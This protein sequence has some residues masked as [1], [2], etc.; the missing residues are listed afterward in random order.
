MRNS[1]FVC[2][3]AGAILVAGMGFNPVEAQA[4]RAAISGTVVDST[5]AAVPGV[6]IEVKNTGTG[7]T[8]TVLTNELGR[9]SIP[10]I[11]IGRVDVR[12]TLA[13]FQSILHEEVTL[14]V[15]SQRVIDFT[16]QVG[17]ASETV[18]GKAPVSRVNTTSAA[19]ASTVTQ[20]QITDLPLNGRNF[21]QLIL[22]APGVQ[23]AGN[24][25]FSI[26]GSRPDGYAFLLDNT[27]IQGFWNRGAHTGAL[28]TTLGVEA[29]AEFQTLTSTYSAQ[30]GGNGA[31]INIVTKPGTN[32]VHGS[33]FEFL[34]NNAL[35]AANFFDNYSNVKK[36]PF[37]RNQFGGSLGGPIRR[38]KAFFFFNYEGLQQARGLT[39][40]ATVP[41][42]N[43]HNGMI[44]SGG[45]ITPVPG[46]INPA[47]KRILDLYPLPTTLV[48]DIFGR[49]TGVGQI[50]S[51]ASQTGSENYF[52]SRTDYVLSPK[53]QLL[54]RYVNDGANF[55]DPFSGSAIPLWPESDRSH[56]Q[57]MTIE[58]ERIFSPSLVNLLRFSFVRTFE[59]AENT[60]HVDALQFFA[61]R[62]N[63]TVS[64]GNGITPIGSNPLAPFRIVQNKFGYADDAYWNHGAHNIRFGGEAARVQSNVFVP[65]Q[66]GGVWTFSG[67]LAFL[68]N[69]PTS[70]VAAL[71]GQDDATRDFR[72]TDLTGYVHDDWKVM[73]RVTLNPGLRY[74]FVTNPV[75]VRH[76]LFARTD[77]A[78][79][80]PYT[81]VPHV[82]KDNP[83]LKNFDP[84]IGFAWDP[85]AN[86]R[87]S[88]RGGFGVFHNPIV[89]AA[90]AAAYY[91]S[92]PYV[93]GRQDSPVFPNTFTS[94]TRVLPAQAQGLD[95]GTKDTPYQMQWSLNVQREIGDGNVA[96]IGY[97]GSRGIHQGNSDYNSLQASLDRRFA[98]NFSVTAA[99]T[100]SKCADENGENGLDRG[101][102][103]FG[104]THN[105]SAS[106]IVALPFRGNPLI[107]GWEIT[108]IVGASTGA[109][110]FTV[111][112]AGK[113]G[114]AGRNVLTGPG[115]ANVDLALIKNTGIPS[116]A[117][118]FN[119]QFR[120]EF[121][122]VLNHANFGQPNANVSAPTAGQIRTAS[123]SR[124]IQFALRLLF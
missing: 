76:P 71:P 37:R 25:T 66:W 84:R 35:D 100:W 86:H 120:A 61:G 74:S 118:S 15:G 30:F 54:V 38:D 53:D 50:S 3:L 99:Y 119:V 11:A 116:I 48:R 21:S 17:D 73:S 4:L 45:L 121:F 63:G 91:S 34:R 77:P 7:V 82:F 31:A 9:Y 98:R 6:S 103:N 111:P 5:G 39:K 65:Y 122:N 26:S 110:A 18:A 13:G 40:I 104:R 124:Q 85:F 117:E 33:A 58:E 22:L 27:N 75:G 113:P 78:T 52:L 109:P 19:V 49:P 51:V 8:R 123:A 36:P 87:T 80:A 41:D 24:D 101:P 69:Q 92:P 96:A 12:A 70:L 107:A 57:Y 14:S 88:I 102:C 29:I 79:S 93:I 43:T 89:P 94:V 55:V 115:Y 112:A 81:P 62:V 97:A 105:F 42:V 32:F 23:P 108:G 67:I 60:G 44:I 47:T 16:L 114:N 1:T 28:G 95:Y 20:K 106:S 83:S 72:E 90:Y 2:A 68:R 46:G 10:E 59:G 56:N 64:P